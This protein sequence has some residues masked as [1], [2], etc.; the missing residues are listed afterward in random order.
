M[1]D[2]E[3]LLRPWVQD[4]RE[5]S[6]AEAA[7]LLNVSKRRVERAREVIE[8][9]VPDLVDAVEHGDVKVST[10]A[11]FAKAVP[12]QDQA[13][14]IDEHGSPASAVKATVKAKADR[15]A[16]RTPKPV[17]DPKPAADRA[18]RD[19]S[20]RERWNQLS[21]LLQAFLAL[22]HSGTPAQV[23]KAVMR[24]ET[25][26]TSTVSRLRLVAAFANEVV[27]RMEDAKASGKN[28]KTS[29]TAE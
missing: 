15:A 26:T 21:G 10:A 17:P 24:L 9:G 20:H 14:L 29:A 4:M 6:Q 22:D 25:D 7:K 5:A 2:E 19:R 12:P 18:E 1:A 28:G 16:V 13:R 23:A 3:A 8:K 11:E 27:I